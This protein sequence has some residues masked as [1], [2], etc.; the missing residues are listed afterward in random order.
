MF[1]DWKKEEQCSHEKNV[2]SGN[3]TD[4]RDESHYKHVKNVLK[5]KLFSQLQRIVLVFTI[6]F[7]DMLF[8][9]LFH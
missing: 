8:L 9:F 2:C 1:L 4:P 7:S 6:S 3:C 5:V